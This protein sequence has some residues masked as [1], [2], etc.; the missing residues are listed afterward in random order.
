MPTTRE[1][2]KQI[3]PAPIWQSASRA[4]YAFQRA[5]LWPAATFHPLRRQSVRGL[6][7]F[8]DLHRGQRC[9]IIGNGPSL[10][11][12]DLSPLQNEITFGMNR[13]YL[14][15]PELGFQTT[16]FLTVNSLVN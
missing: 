12:M 6:A 16:Y 10:K 15:F 11:Q 8:E 1:H 5:T 4:W 3:T 9:F 7:R 14:M 13:I 2:L